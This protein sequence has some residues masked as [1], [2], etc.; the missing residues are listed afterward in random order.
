MASS[1]ASSTAAIIFDRKGPHARALTVTLPSTK[2]AKWRV[3]WW[4]AAF[5]DEYA[6]VSRLGTET[7]LMDPMLMIRPHASR[8]PPF[9]IMGSRACVRVNT[10]WTLSVK[11]FVNAESG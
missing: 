4:S 10:R 2:S 8:L 5:D 1:P 6:N 7:P 9:S 11:S 3:S